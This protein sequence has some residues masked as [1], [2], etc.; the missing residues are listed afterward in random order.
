MTFQK[1]E[2]CESRIAFMKKVF[3]CTLEVVKKFV[4]GGGGV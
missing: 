1:V 2:L 3:L 4:G